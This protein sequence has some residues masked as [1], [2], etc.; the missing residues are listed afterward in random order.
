MCLCI[1][2]RAANLKIIQCHELNADQWTHVIIVIINIVSRLSVILTLTHCKFVFYKC[3]HFPYSTHFWNPSPRIASFCC[4]FFHFMQFLHEKTHNCYS[5]ST[6]TA[7]CFKGYEGM[8][9][10]KQCCTT[11]SLENQKDS[12]SALSSLWCGYHGV[13][14]L[15]PYGYHNLNFLKADD[16]H[17]P[18][19]WISY[20]KDLPTVYM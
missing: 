3:Y 19:I 9:V 11:N 2:V 20:L 18:G 4:L 8:L 12:D 10:W 16:W 6:G 7:V 1:L 15:L 13:I 17:P 14:M 5:C